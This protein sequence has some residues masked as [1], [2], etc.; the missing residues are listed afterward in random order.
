MTTLTMQGKKRIE[1]IGGVFRGE[2]TVV[3]AA[4]ILDISERQCYRTKA[5]VKVLRVAESE[6]KAKP[7]T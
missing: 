1:I 2:L 7:L 6:A 4:T 3:E 5:R